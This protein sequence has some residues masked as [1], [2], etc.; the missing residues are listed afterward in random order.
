[1]CRF[2]A[3]LCDNPFITAVVF[4]VSE[5]PP[6]RRTEPPAASS[7]RSLAINIKP[8]SQLYSTTPAAPS[9][10]W[11]YNQ[12]IPLAPLSPM[13]VTK[14][15]CPFC[16][17]SYE[18]KSSLKRHLRLDCGKEL[19]FVCPYCD[20]HLGDNASLRAHVTNIH[21]EKIPPTLFSM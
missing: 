15:T 10:S 21:P 13:S 11:T 5:T 7:A 19:L 4:T 18:Y 14:Y 16:A 8:A 17:K 12:N 9:T 3:L 2:G 20:T 6:S 1:M